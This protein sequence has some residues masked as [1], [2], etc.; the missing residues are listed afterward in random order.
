M[1]KTESEHATNDP[2]R[3]ICTAILFTAVE[4][5]KR[6]GERRA[7]YLASGRDI[8]KKAV[9]TWSEVRAL[10]GYL[11]GERFELHVLAIDQNEEVFRKR[12]LEMMAG[13]DFLSTLEQ[14]RKC[15]HC[16]E[17]RKLET[18]FGERI[19]NGKK[20]RQSWCRFCRNGGV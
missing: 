6:I 19:I 16:G 18:D 17:L 9:R 15:P 14:T 7:Q 1:P 2:P 4:D 13:V 11:Y 3:A 20:Y 10:I 5:A 12:L 8:P